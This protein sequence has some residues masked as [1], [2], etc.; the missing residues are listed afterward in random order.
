MQSFYREIV[1]DH[2]QH[3]RNRRAPEDADIE[4]YIDNPG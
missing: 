4:E 3:P 1:L 2:F